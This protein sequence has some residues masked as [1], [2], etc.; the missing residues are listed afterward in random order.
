MNNYI[1]YARSRNR[2]IESFYELT[3]L[4]KICL[5]VLF[6][7]L[8]GLSAQVYVRLPFTPVPITGQVFLVLLSGMLLGRNFG[9]LSQIIYLLGGT[10]GLSWLAGGSC[11][12]LK[13]TFGYIIGFIFASYYVGCFSE[14]PRGNNVWLLS[15]H[16]LFALL[17][18][19]A[20]G[21]VWLIFTL[22]ISLHR[23]FLLGILPFLP[24]D[25]A[26]AYA[27]AAI[28]HKTR[29]QTHIP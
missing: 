28:L 23:G 20:C 25:I 1:S 16:M 26:K 12:I 13:P 19:Y 5:S 7:V 10:M 11:A 21:L 6:A 24:L 17:I 4:R 22:R 9:S 29:I 8:T 15:L 3:L 14:K 27:A 18:I 2:A